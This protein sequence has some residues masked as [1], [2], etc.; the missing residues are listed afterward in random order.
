M[1]FYSNATNTASAFWERRGF[2][3]SK[4]DPPILFRSIA[5]V[6]ASLR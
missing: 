5:D 4:D 3:P 2:I 1:I 6:A